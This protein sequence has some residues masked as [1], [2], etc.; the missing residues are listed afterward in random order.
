MTRWA[1][2]ICPPWIRPVLMTSVVLAVLAAMAAVM[3]VMVLAVVLLY[4]ATY[5]YKSSLG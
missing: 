4:G 2:T 3:V 5:V 1:A